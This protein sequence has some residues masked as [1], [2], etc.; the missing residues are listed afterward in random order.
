VIVGVALLAIDLRAASH[1]VLTLGGLAALALGLASLFPDAPAPYHGSTALIV[2]LTVVVGGLW[3]IV[4]G[5][6]VAARRLPVSVGPHEILGK[7][8]IVDEKGLVF[9]N[10]ELWQ[11]R[12][13]EPLR[14]GQRVQVDAL[15]GLTLRVHHVGA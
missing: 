2:G 6:A 9:V 15:D 1:G 5:K 8:G 4:A 13:S 12:S 10:G 3:A 14:P 11:A 7:H